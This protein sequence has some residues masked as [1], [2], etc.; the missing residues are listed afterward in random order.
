MTILKTIAALGIFALAPTLAGAKPGSKDECLK[1]GND[2]LLKQGCAAL[3]DFMRTFNL[4]DG[5]AWAATRNFP[6]VRLA[7]EHIQTW[8]TPEEYA[9]SNDVTE[10]ANNTGWSYSKWTS[11]KLVQRSDEK[12]HF[13]VQ[14]TR[15]A[16]Q[17]SP[18]RPM[19]RSTF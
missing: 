1:P 19:T 4:R 6:H 8:N 5:K 15:Y 7:G 16:A 10:L 3:D 17:D 2:A 18:L 14:F 13:V 9:A 11:R 12:L